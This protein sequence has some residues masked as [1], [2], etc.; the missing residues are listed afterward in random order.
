MR[1]L[2]PAK[3]P[4]FGQIPSDWDEAPLFTYFRQRKSKNKGMVETNVLSLSYGS[5]KRRD[6]DSGMGLLP[7]SFET[8]QIVEPGDIVMRL[9]DLQN[10]KRSLRT[11]LVGE[12]GIVTSA[13]VALAANQRTDSRFAHYLLHSLDTTKVFYGLGAGVRQTMGYGDLSGIP[14]AMPNRLEQRR[15]AD[16]LDSET[17]RIDSLIGRKQSFIE[18]LLEKRTAL[19]TYAVTKG[20]DPNVEMKDSG[21]P[22]LPEVPAQW[23]VHKLGYLTRKVADGPHFSPSYVDDGVMFIS[24]RNIKSDRWAFEDAEH[25]TEDDYT[26]FCRRILPERGDV[27]YT[28]GGTTGIARAVDFDDRFQVWVHVAVLK[29]WRNVNPF[30]LAYALNSGGAYTQSQLYTRGATNNDLGLTRLVNII[31]AVPSGDAQQQIVDY[32]D[33]ETA[34]LDAL[35]GKIL[36]SIEL[37]K[38]YRTALITSAV[39]GQIEIPPTDIGEDVA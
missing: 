25:V 20:L 6:V 26:D 38:E 12:R 13:Y 8:Y 16:Y 22:F 37:L 28:K 14:L 31:V 33:A 27:L 39:T 9:T 4:W 19:I 2:K 15:V 35:V 17:T 24:A 11:G 5:I 18:L 34:K 36:V 29:L 32:L 30:W 23:S 7:Q 1:P 3:A 21:S 10:D